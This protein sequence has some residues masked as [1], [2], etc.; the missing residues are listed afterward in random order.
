MKFAKLILGTVLFGAVS[1]STA[2]NADECLRYKTIAGDAYSTKNYE[3]TVYAY[4]KAQ[5]NCEKLEMVFYNPFIYAIKQSMRNAKT[6]E[7]ETAYLD[8]LIAVYE[9][10][11]EVH[12]LQ[13]DWQTFLGYSYLKQAKPGY[14]KKADEAY[15]IGIHH[16]GKDVNEG[17]VKQYYANLYNLWVQETDEDKKAEYKKRLITEF[18]K[19]SEYVTKGKMNPE[20]V[21]FL[22]IYLE[23]AVTDCESV[24][25]EISSFMNTLPQ[26]KEAKKAAVKNFMALLEKK[27]CT[28]S[29]EYAMLVD[30]IIK[31]DPSVD[32]V[33]AKAKLL[34]AQNKTSE[35]I[36]TFEKALT[37]T[38]DPD[39]K[40]D[41]QYEIA[42]AYFRSRNYRAAHD[43]GLA[44]SGKNSGKG[45]EIAAKSVHALMNDCGDS[46]F[47]RKANMY[48]AIELAKK[49]GN[50]T[51]VEMYK[52]QAPTSTDLFN[53]NKNVG[54]E[55][56]L[57]CWN[58]TYKIETY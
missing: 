24:L 16:E 21:D 41:I 1:V 48:Y 43:A 52:N 56:T 53:V 50:G 57:G 9:K 49:S 29:K 15:R 34:I 44:V 5:E 33:L 55:V 11:Q 2:Q 45:Y 28:S 7:A 51:L 46:T 42:A 4:I 12:G 32:A 40:S 20:T 14:M 13:K 39:M 22:S 30:T 17:F 37:M 3:K 18:F 58:R 25:P 38:E 27:E 19:L 35:A 23:K 47:D 54:E 31:I 6:P 10:A 8:T 26:E 36:K